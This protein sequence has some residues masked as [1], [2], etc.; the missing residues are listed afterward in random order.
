MK[1]ERVNSA[2]VGFVIVE[3]R[4]TISERGILAERNEDCADDAQCDCEK[5]EILLFVL[6]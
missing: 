3:L 4:F 5:R 1:H 6:S 2:F